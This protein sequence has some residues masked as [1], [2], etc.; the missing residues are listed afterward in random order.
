MPAWE[1]F[2]WK[3]RRLPVAKGKPMRT[4]KIIRDPSGPQGTTGDLIA[5]MF[6]CNTLEPNWHDNKPDISCI[7]L[8]TYE[9]AIVD[10]PKYGKVF[11]V[12]V[13]GREHVLFHWGNFAA[14]APGKSD[15]EGCILLG[16][17]I[18]EIAG[19]LALLRSKDAFS[20]FMLEMESDHFTLTIEARA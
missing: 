16:N 4:V 17:A 2:G 5:G 12:K 15:T 13:D 9:C 11:G 14:D 18:G 10:S 1:A 3:P 7:P 6:Y 20:R 19:Q 8:G